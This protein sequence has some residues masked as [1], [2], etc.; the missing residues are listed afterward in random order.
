MV[1]GDE[2]VIVNEQLIPSRLPMLLLRLRLG[3]ECV[4]GS[5]KLLDDLHLRLISALLSTGAAAAAAATTAAVVVV[6]VVVVEAT[7][8]VDFDSN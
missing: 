7:A 1:L 3:S 4:A 2:D 6:V 5:R 8:V